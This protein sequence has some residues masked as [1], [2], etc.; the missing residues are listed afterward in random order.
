MFKV[1]EFF[2]LTMKKKSYAWVMKIHRE[3]FILKPLDNHLEETLA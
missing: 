2:E 1:H 3:I